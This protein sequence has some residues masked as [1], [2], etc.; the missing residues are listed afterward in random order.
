[1][2]AN[3]INA[4]RFLNNK[5][6]AGGL[7]TKMRQGLAGSETALAILDS[8]TDEQLVIKYIS[9]HEIK[10]TPLDQLPRMV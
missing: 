8:L 9:H 7:R 6:L 2:Q 5:H 10:K 3:G 4:E 1:M